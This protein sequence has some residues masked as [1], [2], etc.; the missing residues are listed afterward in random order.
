MYLRLFRQSL[1]QQ[2][3]WT[4]V[5]CLKNRTHCPPLYL[6]DQLPLYTHAIASVDQGA[7]II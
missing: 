3:F 7:G 5:T 6:I 1:M 2:C 4:A